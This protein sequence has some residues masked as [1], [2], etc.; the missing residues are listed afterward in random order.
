MILPSRYHAFRRSLVKRG[1]WKTIRF[2]TRRVLGLRTR[3]V[4]RKV[5]HH[6][7]LQYGVHT[8]GVIARD[9]RDVRHDYH[10]VAPSVFREAL[11][12]W[13]LHIPSYISGLEAYTFLDLGC[14][15]GRAL[16]LASQLPFQQVIGV[17]FDSQLTEIAQRNLEPWA[18]AGQARSPIQIQQ[19]DVL[20]Y[21]FPNPPLLVFLYNPFGP[22]I[23]QPVLSRLLQL[24]RETSSPVDLLY[25][26]PQSDF[27]L[28]DSSKF[29]FLIG[30]QVPFDELDRSV[31]D[32]GANQESYALYRLCT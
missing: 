11:R 23:L 10:G 17:E 7:D 24:A 13:Q 18:H 25:V 30:Q 9:E 28:K 32:F 14:G 2:A 27:L 26:H 29:Q 15:M 1:L 4:V 12:E 6:F 3:T 16:L 19:E 20:N 22:S 8:S 21:I 31:D 5:P